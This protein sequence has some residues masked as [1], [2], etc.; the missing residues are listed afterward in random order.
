MLYEIIKIFK[1]FS[2]IILCT[3]AA[4]ICLKYS[5]TVILWNIIII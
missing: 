2:V 5:K 1:D 4:F 3:P